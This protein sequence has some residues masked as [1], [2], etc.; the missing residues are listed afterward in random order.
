VRVLFVTPRL[1][2]PPMSG[3]RTRVYQMLRHLAARHEVVLL[4]FARH[5]EVPDVEALR[6]HG[7]EIH[8]VLS[9]WPAGLWKR[10]MQLGSLGAGASYQR[11]LHQSEAMQRAL[12]RLLTERAF[13]IVQLESNLMSWL[14]LHCAVPVVLDEHNIESE[15]LARTAGEERAPLR[16]LFNRLEC[17]KVRR[18]E[19]SAWRRADACI[20]TSER[21]AE[22]V[23]GLL[24]G[25]HIAVVPNGVDIEYF[26]PTAAPPAPESIVFTGLMSYRPNVDGAVWFVEEVLPR[27]RAA[28]PT[29][30]FT[31]AGA[32][33]PRGVLRLVGPGVQVTG[34]LP[35]MRPVIAEAAVLV[36]PLRMGS[37]TR[38]KVVEGLAMGKAMVST[39]LGCEGI[40]VQDGEHLRMADSPEQFAAAVLH[41]L[42]DPMT[43]ARFGA[44]G[45]EMVE[46]CYGWD[47]IVRRLEETYEVLA[48]RPAP[49][50]AGSLMHEG[51]A[52]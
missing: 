51:A 16:R 34:E 18:E 4:T 52:G 37:G 30:S 43:A 25:H 40:S 47:G 26:R 17:R 36:A 24:P 14:N 22:I 39:S 41:L 8:T 38:L 32:R 28:R 15:L 9:E 50:G 27:I 35:D 13:E 12:D 44:N 21:E 33:P 1:P 45:R 3:F 20:F 49:A 29:A 5:A 23:R 46:R 7:I 19:R 31:I 2:Y 11:R 10:R 6:G 48:Q 42:D